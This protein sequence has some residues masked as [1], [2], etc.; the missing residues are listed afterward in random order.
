MRDLRPVV[1]RD[2]RLQSGILFPPHGTLSRR[3][4]LNIQ[5]C[6]STSDTPLLCTSFAAELVS[7]AGLYR[8]FDAGLP[9]ELAGKAVHIR[10]T[11]KTSDDPERLIIEVLRNN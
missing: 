1:W 2:G 7:V 5:L 3:S 10:L 9:A 4:L 8:T 11:E 6:V